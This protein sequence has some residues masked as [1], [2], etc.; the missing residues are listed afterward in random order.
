[1]SPPEH[2][3]TPRCLLRKPRPGDAEPAFHAYA[4]DVEALRYL[5]WRPNAN[6]AETAAFLSYS[7]HR[8]LKGTAWTY[9]ICSKRD[10]TAIGLIELEPAGHRARLGFVLARTHWGQGLMSETAAAVLVHT[11]RLPGMAR[12]D[13]LCDV[14]NPASARVLEKIGMQ[15]EGRLA[16]YLVHPNAGTQPRDALMYC[17][18]RA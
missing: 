16:R 2:I 1:M 3:E 18:L 8:W 4:S 11:L 14:N 13:A 7:L 5:H 10:R 15:F 6:V 17:A 9:S 12:V